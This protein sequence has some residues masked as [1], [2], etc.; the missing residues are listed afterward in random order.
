LKI[1]KV[2]APPPKSLNAFSLTKSKECIKS[3][4]K[5][6]TDSYSSAMV[7]WPKALVTTPP[8]GEGCV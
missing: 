4:N 7:I 8:P 3:D 2:N 1:E 5:S 6:L